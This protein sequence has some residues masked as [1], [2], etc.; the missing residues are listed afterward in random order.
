M[1]YLKF[2]PGDVVELRSGGLPMTVVVSTSPLTTVTWHDEDGRPQ[3]ASYPTP[4]LELRDQHA[5][6]TQAR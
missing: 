2:Q 1:T 4:C 6:E 5:S 3:N